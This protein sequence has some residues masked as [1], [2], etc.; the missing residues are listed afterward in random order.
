MTQ[1][2]SLL[3]NEKRYSRF[4]IEFNTIEQFWQASKSNVW[5]ANKYDLNL[6][7]ESFDTAPELIKEALR[8]IIAFFAV[9]DG[10]IGDNLCH[11][12]MKES[13]IT[14]ARMYYSM[15]AMIEST[16]V[17]FY[18]NALKAFIEPHDLKKYTEPLEHFP[19]VKR[20]AEFTEKYMDLSLPMPERL[21]AFAVVEGI[22]FQ[23][24]FAFIFFIRTLPGSGNI[25]QRFA[26]GNEEILRDEWD[27]AKFS[28]ANYFAE[29]IKQNAGLVS[30]ARLTEIITSGVEIEK[31]FARDVL[32]DRGMPGMTITQI[33]THIEAVADN[34]ADLFGIPKIYRKTTPFAFMDNLSLSKKTNFHERLVS[35]YT[36]AAAAEEDNS[37]ASDVFDE[38]I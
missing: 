9:A 4:P 32:L 24:S 27:H 7:K 1:T 22:F 12:F 29:S 10:W 8:R 6:D 38:R 21:A 31:A 14:E 13:N 18:H 37:T 26:A 33:E 15:Q 2:L 17:E 5:F 25:C 11:A 35:E 3:G 28:A 20:K 34:V 36:F 16:H 19:S 30:A 23:S